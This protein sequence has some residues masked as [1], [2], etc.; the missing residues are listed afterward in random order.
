MTEAPITAQAIASPARSPR[1]SPAAGLEGGE[2]PTR[3]PRTA[4]MKTEALAT[5]VASQPATL[6]GAKG[7]PMSVA[8]QGRKAA[9]TMTIPEIMPT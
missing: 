3:W 1:R 5:L 8:Y 2:R 9:T 7:G 6:S 4:P